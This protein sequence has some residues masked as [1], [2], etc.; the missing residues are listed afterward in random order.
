[1][2]KSFDRK[3]I[4]AILILAITVPSAFL[5]FL[6]MIFGTFKGYGSFNVVGMANETIAIFMNLSV[7]TALSLA[8][9]VFYLVALIAV[10]KK[11][12]W[13]FPVI[14]DYIVAIK[15]KDSRGIDENYADLIY[16]FNYSFKWFIA[17]IVVSSLGTARDFTALGAVTAIICI[18][19]FALGR[20]LGRLEGDSLPSY[21]NIGIESARSVMASFIMAFALNKVLEGHWL[22]FFLYSL[23]VDNDGKIDK[24]ASRAAVIEMIY[25]IAFAF[26]ILTLCRKMIDYLSD[27]KKDSYMDGPCSYFKIMGVY[28]LICSLIK[29]VMLYL[30]SDEGLHIRVQNIIYV[31]FQYNRNDLLPII[32]ISFSGYWLF[33]TGF[34]KPEKKGI[35]ELAGEKSKGTEEAQ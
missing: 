29:F 19:A 2:K 35:V 11:F 31:Y 7:S 13:V 28:A 25:Y 16:L 17:Y 5:I 10:I 24:W 12:V 4:V 27:N 8:I 32:L 21:V 22:L 15:D 30:L 1:M 18:V 33:R 26:V 3:S 9:G 23:S 34:G 20:I 14:R 6:S